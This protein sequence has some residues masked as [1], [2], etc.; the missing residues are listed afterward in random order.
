MTVEALFGLS[1]L[2]SF[3]GYGIVTRLYIWPWLRAAPR[4]EALVALAAPHMSRFVGLSFLV[5]GVVSPTLSPAFAVPAAY[6]DLGAAILAVLTIWSLS[7]H[8]SWAI[9][10]AWVFNLWGSLDLL[11]AFYQGQIGVRIGP[12]SLGAAYFIPTVVVPALLVTHG[13]MFWLLMR[14]KRS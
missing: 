8:W 9:A 4:D 1:I 3:L 6:G 2:M 14:Q 11:H 7:A 13:L 5:P 12:G 10:I